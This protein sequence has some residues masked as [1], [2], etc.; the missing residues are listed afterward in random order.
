MD[1]KV[2]AFGHRVEETA[3]GG[4]AGFGGFVEGAGGA[5]FGGGLGGGFHGEGG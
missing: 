3:E 5:G 4:G 2:G 1:V